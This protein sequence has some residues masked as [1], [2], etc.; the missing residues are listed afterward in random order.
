MET[1]HRR[2]PC[3]YAPTRPMHNKLVLE[4]RH[5]SVDLPSRQGYLILYKQAFF[6][7]RIVSFSLLSF[8]YNKTFLLSL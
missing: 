3:Q 4:V 2:K 6:S 5:S 7:L 1:N 8:G